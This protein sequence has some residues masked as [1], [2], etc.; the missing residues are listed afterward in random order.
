MLDREVL[1]G[2]NRVYYLRTD[3]PLWSI[4]ATAA[5]IVNWRD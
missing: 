5:S 3:S 1:H 4:V 2:E